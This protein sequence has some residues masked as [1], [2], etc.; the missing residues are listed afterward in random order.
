MVSPMWSGNF[1]S[2]DLQK[3][4]I[5]NYCKSKKAKRK[6]M[7]MYRKKCNNGS[8]PERDKAAEYFEE[9]F[10]S[11]WYTTDEIRYIPSFVHLIAG[12]EDERIRRFWVIH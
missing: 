1:L 7:M 4:Y 11:P 10:L 6:K 12:T 9:I 3:Q 2:K 8:I 5:R